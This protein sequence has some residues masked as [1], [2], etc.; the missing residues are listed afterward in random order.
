[1]KNTALCLFF[2]CAYALFAGGKTEK[3]VVHNNTWTLCIT[4]ADVSDLPPSRAAVASVALQTITRSLAAVDR[5]IRL[6]D[7]EAYYRNAVWRAAEKEAAKKIADKQ[8]QRDN[9]VYR[10]YKQWKYDQEIKKI[11]EELATLRGDLQRIKADT[12]IIEREP[13][14][15][16]TSENLAY[17]FPLP[18]EPDKEY[19]FCTEKKI[20]GFLVSRITEF[21]GRV[22]L[23]VRLY[24]LFARSYTYE[25]SAIFST[26]D[27]EIALLELGD[28]IIE[29]VSQSPPSGIIVRAEPEDAIIAVNRRF[30]GRGESD[31]V[32]RNP[33]PVTVEVF[34]DNHIS[35]SGEVE[36]APEE[37]A[38]FSVRL[39]PLPLAGI[40][41]NTAEPAFLYRGALFLGAAPLS[42]SAPRD[43]WMLLMAE[44]PDKKTAS[45][46]FIVNDGA[47]TI[48]PVVPPKDGAVDKARR[49]FYGAWGRFWIAL[50]LALVIN[51]M[52][53]SYLSAYNTHSAITE[54]DYNRAMTF[55][56]AT[57]GAGVAAG[58]FGVEFAVRLIYY[59]YV[60][61]KERSPLVPP[62]PTIVEAPVTPLATEPDTPPEA[63]VAEN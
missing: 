9:L 50:P 21:H 15:T 49:G 60:S 39:P 38:E 24:S 16:L 51:G 26:E 34:A 11:D 18:P 42:L 55:Q 52:Y 19:Y 4:D 37:L 10:G 48:K 8:S 35:Y 47:I 44:T 3:P 25:D 13:V 41:V 33:G 53:S 1:M 57:I 20:D 7:E 29:H 2:L 58:L 31:L 12:P 54:E 59:V 36:L 63:A 46:A 14:F 5:R 40:T 22:V 56:Y 27:L 28:R 17:T 6:S 30:E 23:E 45:T 61:S 32:E 43:Q 62:A